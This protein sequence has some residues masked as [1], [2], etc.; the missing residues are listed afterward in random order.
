MIH[1]TDNHAS[2]HAVRDGQ[3]AAV[4]C[5]T[6]GCRLERVDGTF[7]HFGRLGGRDA[8][9]CRIDCADSPHDAAGRAMVL[10]A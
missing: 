10:T 3:R 4:S 7:M 1:P 8:R 9:G 5:A 6:C 2:P